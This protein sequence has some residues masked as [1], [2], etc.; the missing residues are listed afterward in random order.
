MIA[1]ASMDRLSW[2]L[3]S[4]LRSSS[5]FAR[6]FLGRRDRCVLASPVRIL[7]CDKVNKLMA[8][9]LGTETPMMLEPIGELA[10]KLKRASVRVVIA[11]QFRGGG[12]LLMNFDALCFIETLDG[13]GAR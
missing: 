1:C 5:H 11:L 8:H 2:F 3:S 10:S 13:P 6:G 7:A 12:L 9:I 4:C